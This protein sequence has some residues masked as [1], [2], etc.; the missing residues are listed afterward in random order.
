MPQIV[1]LVGVSNSGKTTLLE[2]LIPVLKDRGWRIGTLK[3]D[4]HGFDMD[5]P[6]KDTYR[7][8]EAGAEAVVISGPR[9][10]AVVRE[11]ASDQNPHTLIDRYLSD[12]DLVLVEGFKRYPFP[13]LEIVRAA[14][15]QQPVT[16]HHEL[17]GLIT[18]LDLEIPDVPR[19]RLDDIQ[20]IAD[21]IETLIQ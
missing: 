11:E 1:A 18:D 12:M 4:A 21:R 17:A 9:R 8:R 20:A 15:S 13:K 6:G 16:P 19:F 7:H 5:H 3:H 14:R 10:I 2:K